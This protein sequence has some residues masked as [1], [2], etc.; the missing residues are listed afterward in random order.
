MMLRWLPV[1]L[2]LASLAG[3]AKQADLPD[4]IASA[5]FKEDFTRFR[6]GL[7]TCF[8]AEQLKKFT[9]PPRNSSSTR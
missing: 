4:I 7:D 5:A 6:A 3:G 9:P 2:F 8:A 1:V